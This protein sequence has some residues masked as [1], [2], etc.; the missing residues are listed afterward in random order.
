M[1]KILCFFLFL[2]SVGTC[3][4]QSYIFPEPKIYNDSLRNIIINDTIENIY[5]V[6]LKPRF[7]TSTYES[8]DWTLNIF[9]PDRDRKSVV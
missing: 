2:F 5:P 9:L 7:A 3:F 8:C 1:K 4:S 6:I